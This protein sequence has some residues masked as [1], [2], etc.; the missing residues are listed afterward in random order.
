MM[1]ASFETYMKETGRGTE[2]FVRRGEVTESVGYIE[3]TLGG[4]N[5][6]SASQDLF[7]YVDEGNS[8]RK[9]NLDE[10]VPLSKIK[11]IGFGYGKVEAGFNTSRSV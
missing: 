10:E 1:M 6:V 5:F 4:V 9:L 2:I 3:R 8:Y 7:C 11:S